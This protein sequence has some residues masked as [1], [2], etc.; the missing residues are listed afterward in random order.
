MTNLAHLTTSRPHG[1]NATVAANIRAELAYSETSQASLASA[2]GM[3]EM[4]L[5]RRLNSKNEFT[6][7][8]IAGVA[9]FLGIEPGDL[10]VVRRRPNAPAGAGAAKAQ[11]MDY[12]AAGSVIDLATFREDRVAKKA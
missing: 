2:L 4:A 8:E 12:K 9:T 1:G 6:A 11:P 3:S 5:S 7:T 10:F